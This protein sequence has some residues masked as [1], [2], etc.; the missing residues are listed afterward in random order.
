MIIYIFIGHNLNPG[1][2]VTDEKDE[3][4]INQT[5]VTREFPEDSRHGEKQ[6]I[7]T[8]SDRS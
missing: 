3:T 4:F 8:R 5:G 7:I 2:L 6:E 1:I